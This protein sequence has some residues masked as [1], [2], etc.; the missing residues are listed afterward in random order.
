MKK[1]E[2]L[3]IN[4]TILWVIDDCNSYE[5]NGRIAKLRSCQAAVYENE[6]YYILRSYNTI[7]AVIDKQTDTLYDF[8][9]LVYGYTA[10]SAQHITKFGKD[11]GSGKWGVTYRYTYYP[12]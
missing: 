12:V 8:L 7:I 2:Q 5:C 3:S 11:F 4:S 1:S 9:R 10:T 6:K